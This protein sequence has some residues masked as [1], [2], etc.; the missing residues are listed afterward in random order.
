MINLHFFI[1][2]HPYQTKLY[3]LDYFLADTVFIP[4]Y[5]FYP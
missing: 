5:L 2:L 1:Y 3:E 4:H